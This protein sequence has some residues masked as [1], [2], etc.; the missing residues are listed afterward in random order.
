MLLPNGNPATS[1]LTTID[2]SGKASIE[3]E[4][5]KD[6]LTEGDETF[7][8]SL[9]SDPNFVSAIADPVSVIIRDTSKGF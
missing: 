2:N 5:I 3:Y 8:V 4:T 7:T 6:Q 9:F 1:G